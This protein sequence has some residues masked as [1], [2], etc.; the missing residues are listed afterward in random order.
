[1]LS[2]KNHTDI[3]ASQISTALGVCL[4]LW[5]SVNCHVAVKPQ[6]SGTF[7]S[8]QQTYILC[9]ANVLIST[10][11]FGLGYFGV[12]C[13][14]ISFKLNKR[15]GLSVQGGESRFHQCSLSMIKGRRSL[16]ALRFI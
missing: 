8:L 11:C 16:Q 1:M 15:A 2:V 7:H 13:V 12:I 3:F 5:H 10:S 6:P 14:K 4:V 9:S